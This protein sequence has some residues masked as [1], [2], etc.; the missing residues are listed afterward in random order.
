MKNIFLKK[1]LL[2]RLITLNLYDR[3]STTTQASNDGFTLIELLVV[4]II[5]GIL[6]VIAIPTFLNQ[7]FKAKQSE[8]K[9]Y[10]SAINRAQKAYFTE[11]TALAPNLETLALDIVPVTDS[12][13]YTVTT[14]PQSA[15]GDARSLKPRL[16]AYTGQVFL[17]INSGNIDVIDVVALS[18][19]CEARYPGPGSVTAPS[20]AVCDSASSVQVES[21]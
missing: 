5:L 6:A 17:Y 15:I 21:R 19:M 8:A 18:V 4:I 10:V 14:A 12:Y 20:N 16:K 9:I 7:T 11:K 13:A 1:F 2:Q 3:R